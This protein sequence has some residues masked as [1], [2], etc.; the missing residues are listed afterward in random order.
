VVDGCPERL[1][2]LD[3]GEPGRVGERG[4]ALAAV[5]DGG[6]P[7][8]AARVLVETVEAHQ[9]QVAQRLGQ[10]AGLVVEPRVEQLL[11]EEGVAR[12]ALH[13]RLEL[14][15]GEPAGRAQA[16]QGGDIGVGERLELDAA[17]AGQPHPLGD[18]LPQR[19]PAVQVVG[20]VAH[21]DVH[22]AAE[23]LREDVPDEMARGGVGPVRVLDDEQQRLVDREGV[24]RADEGREQLGPLDPRPG[25][26]RRPGQQRTERRETP[27]Q[28]V[29]DVVGQPCE[30][31]R[32]RLVG[33]RAVAEV[34][35][36]AGH[37]AVTGLAGAEP[38]LAEQPGL[39]DAG[40][41]AE[42]HDVARVG[43]GHPR[44]A[45]QQVELATAADQGG[46]GVPVVRHAPHHGGG[47]RQPGSRRGH[48]CAVR[49][50]AHAASLRRSPRWAP[51]RRL[52]ATSAR[53]ARAARARARWRSISRG[54]KDSGSMI[55]CPA[56]DPEA[57]PHIGEN[58]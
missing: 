39:A 31:L 45:E 3:V 18:G 35:A 46:R 25:G 38:Q 22:G 56:S 9:Q 26:G 8:E 53:A 30:R 14:V 24:E 19:V 42:Q 41:S 15:A 55:M 5:G 27:G 48:T 1:V 47:H 44:V 58:P 50:V 40:V 52:G 43:I 17:D 4:E 57:G 6:C 36:V 37:D 11:D 10:R 12:G 54:T 34:E 16:H 29:A 20:P 32:E 51:G 49:P 2:E 33:Q 7:H 28:A 21:D 23:P 13:D